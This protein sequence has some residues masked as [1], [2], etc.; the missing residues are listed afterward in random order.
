MILKKFFSV[1]VAGVIIFSLDSNAVA[2]SFSV[3]AGIPVQRSLIEKWDNGEQIESQSLSGILVHIKFPI[4]LGVGYE[5]VESKINPP[6]DSWTDVKL[7]TSM[8]DVFYLFPISTIN[9]TLGAGL[10]SS[11]L[12]CVITIKK[13]SDHWE[14]GSIGSA[15]QFWGQLGVP[16]TPVFDLHVSYHSITSKIKGLNGNPD[17]DFSGTMIG[18]GAAFIF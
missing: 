5:S 11:T 18:F 2:E 7:S 9:F 1:F 4:M 14:S 16:V 13:C 3:S 15:Y 8:Y 10:G 12:S 17:L 6:N